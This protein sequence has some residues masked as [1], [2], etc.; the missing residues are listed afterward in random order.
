LLLSRG[1]EFLDTIGNNQTGCYF[2]ESGELFLE[3]NINNK[4]IKFLSVG[5]FAIFTKSF[6]LA[7]S[8][9]IFDCSKYMDTVKTKF[10]E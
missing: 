8:L 3:Q 4:N 10:V 6:V 2:L 5:K 1:A 7:S 9:Y